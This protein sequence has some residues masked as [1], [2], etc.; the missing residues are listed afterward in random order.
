M[1]ISNSMKSPDF[2]YIDSRDSSVVASLER[3]A[4]NNFHISKHSD[5]AGCTWKIN[6]HV[7]MEITDGI[8]DVD[9]N[10]KDPQLCA[11]LAYDIYN[12]LRTA[13]TKKRASTDFME[14]V[15]KDINPSMRSILIDWLVEVAEEYRLMP[16]T[17][18]LTVITSIGIFLVMRLTA[19]DYNCW[20][21]PAC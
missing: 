17:L 6:Y 21:L 13:E 10:H 2:E 12:H 15:Q 11:T 18:Y 4:T 9:N 8:V 19:K 1:S 3:R 20:K 5:S 16:D 7:A 14:R